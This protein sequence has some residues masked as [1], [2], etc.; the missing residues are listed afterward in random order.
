MKKNVLYLIVTIL[1]LCALSVC[2]SFS[3]SAAAASLW[4]TDPTTT[5]GKNVSVVVDIKGENIGGYEMNITY[6]AEKLK[7]VSANG[8]KGSFSSVDNGGVIR[9]AHYCDSGSEK[10]L[11]F[12]LTFKTLKTGTSKLKPSNYRFFDG[13]GDPITPGAIGDSTIKINPAP[14]ASSDANL[15]SLSISSGT[16]SPVFDPAVTKYTV[17]VE[18]SVESIT[19]SAVCNDAKAK[20]AV[21]GNEKLVVGKNTVIATVTAENGTKKVY[22][23]EVTRNSAAQLP[24]NTDEA[25]YVTLADGNISIVAQ[26]LDQSIVPQGFVLKKISFDGKE[27]DAIS[28]SETGKPAVYL[29]EGAGVTA[30]FYFVDIENKTVV[31]LEYITQNGGELTVLNVDSAQ[32]PDG[33]EI[34]KYK[35]GEVERDALVPTDARR[36]DHCLIYAMKTSGEPMLYVYDPVENTFQ[37]Y[38]TVLSGSFETETSEDNQSAETSLNQDKAP[39]ND[40]KSDDQSL[41]SNKIV[42]WAF[43]GVCVVIVVFIGV[44]IIMNTK[45]S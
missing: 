35:I 37:R 27:Y 16:L 45:Y 39:S 42:M 28:Y 29:P 19:V 5:L 30:G 43:V 4:F 41:F 3:V 2:F 11:S 36:G 6:D 33:Y 44:A 18:P 15:K 10:S 25:V 32:I 31:P 12:T 23:L 20:V 1:M 14:V 24:S 22:T 13:S 17:T 21:T 9:V 34:G 38:G 26:V 40:N 8:K 7:F